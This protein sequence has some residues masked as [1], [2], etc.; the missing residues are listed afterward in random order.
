MKDNLITSNDKPIIII[1]SGTHAKVL[2]HAL[3]NCGRI[4]LGVTDPYKKVGE[5]CND[6][7][8]LGNDD[9]VFEYSVNEIEL[10]N[11]VAGI[12]KKELRRKLTKNLEDKGYVFTKV[13]HP[14]AIIADG[15]VL[16]DGAQIMAGAI[17]QPGVKIGHS[18]IINTGS[19]VDHDCIIH[20][21][22]H[23]APGVT[24]NGNVIIGE[25]TH[26]GTGTSVIENK[27]IGQDCIIAAGSII[28]HDIPAN[29]KFIQ[30]REEKK[31][32]LV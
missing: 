29:T 32:V 25:R 16:N 13:V 18:S 23:I 24:L 10:V 15:V 22:C 7:R 31:E 12:N 4:I 20:N 19:I 9:I 28:H 1:G 8:V 5:N 14:S 6:V 27:K 26:V 2:I 3:K 21:D 17:L 30:L 11:S